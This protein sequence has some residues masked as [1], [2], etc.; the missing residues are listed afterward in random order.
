LSDGVSEREARSP[1]AR[2]KNVFRHR[3]HS[4]F[5]GGQ[6]GDGI[7]L[8]D[9]DDEARIR[10]LS[11]VLQLDDSQPIRSQN[12]PNAVETSFNPGRSHRER[13]C[14]SSS[15]TLDDDRPNFSDLEAEGSNDAAGSARSPTNHSGL[16]EESGGDLFA[17]W[18]HVREA[19]KSKVAEQRANYDGVRHLVQQ[20]AKAQQSKPNVQVVLRLDSIGIELLSERLKEVF[21]RT[22]VEGISGS[23]V[24]FEN[25]SGSFKADLHRIGVVHHVHEA[26]AHGATESTENPS[27]ARHVLAPFVS[28]EMFTSGDVQAWEDDADDVGFSEMCNAND[29]KDESSV[30]LTL[31]RYRSDYEYQQSGSFAKRLQRAAETQ[32]LHEWTGQRND[33]MIRAHARM[34]A[35]VGGIVLLRHFEVNVCPLVVCL[36]HNVITQ[37]IE[38]IAPTTKSYATAVETTE[39]D[40][41]AEFLSTPPAARSATNVG[42][43]G[44]A[45]KSLLKKLGGK[46]LG[47]ASS[48]SDLPSTRNSEGA[49]ARE[50]TGKS[51]EDENKADTDVEVMRNRAA[52][53]VTFKH[54]RLGEINVFVSYR[55]KGAPVPGFTGQQ[56]ASHIQDFDNMHVRLHALVYSNRTCSIPQ[57]LLVMRKD[58]IVDVLGQVSRNF[59]NIGS[60]LSHKMGWGMYMPDSLTAGEPSGVASR[61][62]EVNEAGGE[63]LLFGRHDEDTGSTGF[64]ISNL[65]AKLSPAIKTAKSLAGRRDRSGD[66]EKGVPGT[67]SRYNQAMEL[68]EQGIITATERDQIILADE[69]F[70]SMESTTSTTSIPSLTVSPNPSNS[71]LR[72]AQSSSTP[73]NANGTPEMSDARKMLFGGGQSPPVSSP[74][75]KRWFQK[76]L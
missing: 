43:R 31:V 20:A 44:K 27:S 11:G 58:I 62:S 56:G 52:I 61:E 3:R 9:D 75:K 40:R 42:S 73:S 33:H 24:L 17:W 2:R 18:L 1:K 67:S 21:L 35:P 66:G 50:S 10:R 63:H 68:F 29:D 26:A 59:N 4:S 22:F 36:S 13:L 71:L 41:K 65:P 19:L 47:T 15:S 53:N 5:S 37:L 12:V 8:F 60:F 72:A 32:R 74:K 54:I 30:P 16:R 39:K 64:S 69:Q 7:S 25:G 57:L 14:V 46:G 23:V 6:G 51:L 55:G 48:S 70:T 28:R 38:F 34:G 76:K 45:A 49:R